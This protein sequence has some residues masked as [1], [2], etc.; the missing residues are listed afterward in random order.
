[1]NLTEDP[2]HGKKVRLRALKK[3]DLESLRTW[4]NRWDIRSETREFRLL[5]HDNQEAW[6]AS[7][8]D[9]RTTLMFGIEAHEEGRALVGVCGLTYID[10]R[11][12]HTELSCYIGPTDERKKGY[13]SD[14]LRVMMRYAFEELRLHMVYGEIFAWNEAVLEACAK[15]GFRQEGPLR[16]R[17]LR[18]GKWWGSYFVSM[19]ERE[20][21]KRYETPGGERF[22]EVAP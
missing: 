19:T 6:W 15:L 2:L 16:D 13:Y 3:T 21:V 17:V 18:S 14:A 8:A 10:W 5:T 11:N 4:R 9:D 7:L 1:M 12:G 20:W 22:G